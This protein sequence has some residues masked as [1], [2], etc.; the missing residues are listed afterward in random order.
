MAEGVATLPWPSHSPDLNPIENFW[1]A[2]DEELATGPEPEGRDAFRLRV[3]GI[4]DTFSARHPANFHNLYSSMHTR[5]CAVVE[6]GGLTEF[7]ETQDGVVYVRAAGC[8][9]FMLSALSRATQSVG[10]LL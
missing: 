3:A 5:L 6:A 7:F 10:I 8:S 1:S 2:V 9:L 4:L